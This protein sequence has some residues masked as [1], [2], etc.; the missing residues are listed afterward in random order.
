MPNC[1]A[2]LWTSKV[3]GSKSIA[4]PARSV[5]VRVGASARSAVIVRRPSAADVVLVTVYRARSASSSTPVL[6]LR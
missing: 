5:K 3:I 6:P 1:V 2:M 4:P